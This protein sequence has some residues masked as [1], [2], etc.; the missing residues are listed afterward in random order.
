LCCQKSNPNNII[1]WDGEATL[2]F[3]PFLIHVATPTQPWTV[4]AWHILA[5]LCCPRS[6]SS[7]VPCCG[8]HTYAVEISISDLN[9]VTSG[10]T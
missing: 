10:L 3:G 8:E 5:M 6:L 1:F 7:A 2:L 9:S 4:T